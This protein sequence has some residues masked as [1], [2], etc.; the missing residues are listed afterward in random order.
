MLW[1][2]EFGQLKSVYRGSLNPEMVKKKN[3]VSEP[4]NEGQ[5]HPQNT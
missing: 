2:Y 4:Q 5:T 3:R 1:F